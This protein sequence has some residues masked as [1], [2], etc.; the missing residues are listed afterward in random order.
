[1]PD[2]GDTPAAEPRDL[3]AVRARGHPLAGAVGR[4]RAVELAGRDRAVCRRAREDPRLP[5]EL[6]DSARLLDA[7]T[8]RTRGIVTT[9]LEVARDRPRV[10]RPSRS[11]SSST[12]CSTCS[13]GSG[14]TSRSSA[15]RP[16]ACR[17]S[18]SDPSRLRQLLVVLLVDALRGLGERPRGGSVR[19]GASSDDETRTPRRWR[20]PI[21][22]ADGAP[23]ADVTAL[24][25][26][27]DLADGR[28]G[29]HAASGAGGRRRPPA[30][31]PC[32]A[33]ATAPAEAARPAASPPAPRAAAGRD[34]ARLRRRGLDPC[35]ARP[36]PRARRDARRRRGRRTRRARDPRGDR[37][38]MRSLTDQH[39]AG[40]SGI[41]LY[42]AAM[43]G[44]ARARP[45]VHRHERRAGRGRPGPASR[46]RPG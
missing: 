43:R 28:R 21:G 7:E 3:D 41:E 16:R 44:A 9:L 1:M 19:I 42:T 24:L 22:G 31:S 8:R 17:R 40:M 11:T 6:R 33:P 18:E 45:P 14:S 13:R 46:T 15:S 20:S 23:A 35:A 12:R 36:D 34:R 32:R 39:L 4:A 29:R 10:R 25:P 26:S 5:S 38:W 30:A 2:A 37:R 27:G